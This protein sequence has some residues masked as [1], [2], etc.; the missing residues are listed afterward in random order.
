MIDHASR[1]LAILRPNERGQV[2]ILMVMVLP[3]IF[4]LFALAFDAGL[5]FLDHR[6]AQNQA[7][8]AVLAAVQHLPDADPG[9]GSPATK[10]VHKWLKK[11]GSNPGQL[12]SCP[13]SIPAPH[14]VVGSGGL[15]YYDLHPKS[16]PDGQYDTVRV[17]VRRESPVIFAQ[18]ASLE[19]MFV[20][21]G[22]TAKVAPAGMA[23][24]LSWGIVPPDPDCGIA[25]PDVCEND[26]DS[27]GMIPCG[28]YPPALPG[29]V[30]CPWGLDLDKL[31]AFKIGDPDTYTPGNFGALASC[32]VGIS[33]YVACI[34]GE[35]NSGFYAAGETVNVGAQT[36]D[37]GATTASALNTRYAAE[38][39]MGIRLI[40]SQ[41]WTPTARTSLELCLSLVL[42]AITG[43]WPSQS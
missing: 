30:M 29:E 22:A 18:L 37:G 38:E 24:V 36:G 3:V 5:W 1:R 39:T 31:Y 26:L 6:M 4:L 41:V 23:N 17:C 34:D 35:T 25:W 15:E 14:L 12:K 19:S 32:G 9:P 33:D 10:A 11:N 43:S 21:A 42:S 20:S 16:F 28:V 8:A 2:A 27:E 13:E 40:P 7:D